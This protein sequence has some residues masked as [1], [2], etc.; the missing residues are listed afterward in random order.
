MK[1]IL[2]LIALA[3]IGTSARADGPVSRN[4]RLE[5]AQRR[6]AGK[7]PEECAR[8]LQDYQGNAAQHLDWARARC[9]DAQDGVPEAERV[10]RYLNEF[11][12]FDGE[13]GYVRGPDGPMKGR[14]DSKTLARAFLPPGSDGKRLTILISGNNQRVNEARGQEGQTLMAHL[15]YALRDRGEP[16]LWFRSGD[17]LTQLGDLAERKGNFTE[18]TRVLTVHTRLIAGDVIRALHPSSVSVVGYSWGG[19]K[20]VDLS[21]D[22]SWLQGTRVDRTIAVDPVQCGL[23]G[24]GSAE[25]RRPAF[26]GNR[27][28]QLYQQP[29]PKSD[30]KKPKSLV[31]AGGWLVERSKSAVVIH[32]A[33]LA[34]PCEGDHCEQ[35]QGVDH[36][37]INRDPEIQRR[38]MGYL[39]D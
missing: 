31:E 21:E 12:S 13:Q 10:A 39:N 26:D 2:L 37:G 8:L 18:D 7:P 35:I 28:I 6:W 5:T 27:H 33:P 20:A 1:K 24:L 22:R 36:S 25:T 15:Y 32:G 14:L 19:G 11:V 34:K 38:V 30:R 16:V 4:Y 17:A 9:Q 3:F 29:K 23:H